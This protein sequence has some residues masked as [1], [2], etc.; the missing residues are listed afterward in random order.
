M[1][2]GNWIPITTLSLLLGQELHGAGAPGHLLVNVGLHG[3][4]VLLLYAALA[5]AT[6]AVGASAFVAGVFALHPLHV[7]SVAWLSQRKDV[8]SAAFLGDSP[9]EAMVEVSPG[10]GSKPPPPIPIKNAA[11]SSRR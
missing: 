10:V 2:V 5:A 7:E 9:A 3:L 6:G 1:R 8:L 4:A 11:N